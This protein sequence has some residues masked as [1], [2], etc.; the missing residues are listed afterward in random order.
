MRRHESLRKEATGHQD[1]WVTS[2]NN[3]S[4]VVLKTLLSRPLLFT[5][6]VS[7]TRAHIRNENWVTANTRLDIS[8]A[9]RKMASPQILQPAADSTHTSGRRRRRGRSCPKLWWKQFQPHRPERSPDQ[10]WTTAALLNREGMSQGAQHLCHDSVAT[11]IHRYS[12]RRNHFFF[13]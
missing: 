11:A 5:W 2:I 13:L 3:P 1:S 8:L 7:V 12:R 9:T 10:D 4:P 6:P